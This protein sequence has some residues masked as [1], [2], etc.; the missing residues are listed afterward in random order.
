MD[1]SEIRTVS[2]SAVKQALETIR[3][4]I[5]QFGVTEPTIQRQ[6]EDRILI[7]LPG[8]KEPERAK[9]LLRQTAMLEFKLVNDQDSLQKA[10]EGRV[11]PESE[12]LYE[13]N[14]DKATGRVT[15][16]KGRYC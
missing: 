7:Q 2:D 15:G 13:E 1:K 11:P 16:R 5:D 3:N 4:R 12:I 6:G 9:R 14:V 10:L 8:I